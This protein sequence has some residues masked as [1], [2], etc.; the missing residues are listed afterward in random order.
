IVWQK[1][2]GAPPAVVEGLSLPIPDWERIVFG[3]GRLAHPLF[4]SALIP[5]LVALPAMGW[6]SF[7]PVAA[8]IALGFAGFLAYAAWTRAPGLSWLPF[9]FLALPWLLGNALVSAIL[10]RALLIR[11]EKA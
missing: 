10:A 9:H 4:Y 7:R 3:R 11:R 1:W 6:K 2:V 5:I 8:G